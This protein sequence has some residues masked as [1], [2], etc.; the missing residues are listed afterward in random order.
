M[1]FDTLLAEQ[2]IRIN[3]TYELAYKKCIDYVVDD[4]EHPDSLLEI[5]ISEDEM[6][7]EEYRMQTETWR[8]NN[9][10]FSL[11]PQH[12]EYSAIL[13]K[14]ATEFTLLDIIT[15]HASA[16]SCSGRTIVFTGPSGIGKS[17]RTRVWVEE[18]PES[19]VIN[20]DKPF[21]HVT[22]NNLCA[23]GSPWCGKEGWNSNERGDIQAI[24]LIERADSDVP[25]VE[26]LDFGRA[27]ANLLRL[28]YLPED[29]LHMRKTLR[30]LESCE[31]KTRYYCLRGAPSPKIMH[32]IHE[33]IIH[34]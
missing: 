26:E 24:F 27:S 12:V 7:A 3:A 11:N 15:L 14:I 20:G 8:L 28:V 32:E 6:L 31:N 9:M 19:R 34:G 18:F 1:Y 22:Q 13:R 25:S 21:I 5:S 33:L 16:I 29:S 4:A 2:H 17:T 23:Y 10:Y 30:L